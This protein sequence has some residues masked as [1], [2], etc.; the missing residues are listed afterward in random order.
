MEA[1]EP[2]VVLLAKHRSADAL[3]LQEAAHQA[4][5]VQ[6]TE[7]LARLELAVERPRSLLAAPSAPYRGPCVSRDSSYPR[8]FMQLARWIW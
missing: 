6:P 8:P 2:R 7:V 1:R 4:R 3:T 5:I